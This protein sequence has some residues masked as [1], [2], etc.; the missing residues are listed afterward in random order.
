MRPMLGFKSL[1]RAQSLLA[2]IER[3]NVIRKGQRHH[4]TGEGLSSAEQ[5][6]LLAA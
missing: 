1:R 6:Y 5:F 3:A 4:P 2:G